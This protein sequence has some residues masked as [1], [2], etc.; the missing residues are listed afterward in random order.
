MMNNYHNKI[1]PYL[2]GTMSAEDR[3][4]FEAFVLTHPEFEQEIKT[5]QEELAL[6]KSLIPSI[7]LSKESH[8]S[9]DLEIKQSVLNLLKPEPK[10][11]WD[12]VKL[13]FEEWTNR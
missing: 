4:E 6:L 5:K 9:L 13:K 3:A 2:D 11:I 10:N 1:M 7:H 12:S 8:A